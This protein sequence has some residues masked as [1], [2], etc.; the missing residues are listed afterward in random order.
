[1]CILLA[2]IVKSHLQFYLDVGYLLDQAE[3]MIA[4][5]YNAKDMTFKVFE[6]RNMEIL[7][8]TEFSIASFVIFPT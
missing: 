3:E 8:N 7:G 5:S 4:I 2:K 1:M 6:N